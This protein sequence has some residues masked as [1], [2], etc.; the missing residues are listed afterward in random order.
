MAVNLCDWTLVAAM[1]WISAISVST[2]INVKMEVQMH[3]S[4]VVGCMVTQAVLWGRVGQL[5]QRQ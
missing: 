5:I 3:I 1:A 4:A 2:F